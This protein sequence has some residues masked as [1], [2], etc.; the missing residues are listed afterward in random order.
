MKKNKFVVIT[1]GDPDGIGP[2]VSLKALAKIGPQ[3]NT[4]FLVYRSNF[5]KETQWRMVEKKFTR[6]VV[7]SLEDALSI[8]GLTH[9]HIV[10][11][12]S[13]EPASR[14]VEHAT[15][16]ALR[17]KVHAL[18]TGPLSKTLIKK[19]GMRDI[20]HTEIFAR[21][22]KTKSLTMFFYG[23]RFS[24]ALVS[25]HVPLR[26]ASSRL[27]RS[28]L[29]SCLQNVARASII[30]SQREKKLRVGVVG[31]NPHAGESGLL[32]SEEQH[33]MIPALKLA[34]R[35]FKSLHISD[36]LVPDAAF[37]PQNQKKYDVYVS[38]Y[39]DQGLIPFKMTHEQNVGCQITLGLPFVRTSVDHGTAKE[40]FGKN[41][42]NAGSMV[43]ALTCALALLK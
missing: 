5:F 31:I 27:T 3:K 33:I 29:L 20:G 28:A 2:E 15:R 21:L 24:V 40:L 13:D 19:S 41:K 6:I 11:I 22:A 4:Q 14:W 25:A 16:F 1:T 10:D 35:K 43:D 7:G 17:K 8:P 30:P 32:G 38:P 18:V 37:L 23:P 36:P 34:R 9:K 42:A 39:H 12:C 26:K